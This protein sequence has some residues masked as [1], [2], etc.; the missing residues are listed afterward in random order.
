MPLL[1]IQ[2]CLQGLSFWSQLEKAFHEEFYMGQSK[3]SLKE[4]VSVQR[5]TTEYIDDYLN[6]F[7]LLKA[8]CFT[9]VP[10]HELVE[11]AA[12]GLDYSMQKKL[13]TQYLWDM[14]Q[15]A[16]RVWQVERLKAEK[17]RASKYGGKKDTV[18][19]VNTNDNNQD[20]D[21]YWSPVEEIEV[22]IAEL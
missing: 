21:I 11:M 18:V 22:N 1:G 16:D 2:H 10:G 17:A 13:D 15:L 19:Y 4:L 3:I 9:Q 12:G 5:K 8:R 7:R 6:K 14:A 20:F